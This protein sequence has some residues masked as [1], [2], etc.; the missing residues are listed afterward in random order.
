[1]LIVLMSTQQ[2][3]LPPSVESLNLG[4][5]GIVISGDINEKQKIQTTHDTRS[6]KQTT[7]PV[8]EHLNGF[9]ISTCPISSTAESSSLFISNGIIFNSDSKSLAFKFTDP[10]SIVLRNTF[11]DKCGLSE[12]YNE[13][14]FNRILQFIKIQMHAAYLKNSNFVKILNTQVT[15]YN[16]CIITDVKLFLQNK[17]YTIVDIED[18]NSN[19][20]GWKL[21]W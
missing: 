16:P 4:I 7:V 5:T 19:S 15:Q 3:V 20:I 11:P 14:Q 6:N 8:L 17:H 21:C 1:M 18:C 2:N 12:L 9:I 13:D 10:N